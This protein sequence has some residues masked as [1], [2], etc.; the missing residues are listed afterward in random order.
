MGY[1]WVIYVSGTHTQK[2]RLVTPRQVQAFALSTVWV[3]YTCMNKYGLATSIHSFVASKAARTHYPF[4]MLSYAIICLL[5]ISKVFK[6]GIVL[7]AFLCASYSLLQWCIFFKKPIIAI[8][9]ATIAYRKVKTPAIKSYH[10]AISCMALYIVFFNLQ[11]TP[12]FNANDCSVKTCS[13]FCYGP[14][15][16]FMTSVYNPTS[17]V[18]SNMFLSKPRYTSGIFFS[19]DSVR[20]ILG[21][22]ATLCFLK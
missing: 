10:S 4:I 15:W 1:I 5:C 12:F 22:H 2:R 7:A 19:A 8:A 6:P 3:V 14:L 9:L 21:R 16:N 20:S 18:W 17:V 13:T 11:N